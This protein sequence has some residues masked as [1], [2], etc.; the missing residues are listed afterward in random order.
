MKH[1]IAAFALLIALAAP[2]LAE[3]PVADTADTETA[4]AFAEAVFPRINS[5]SP[6]HDPSSL[7]RYIRFF[8][9]T[10]SFD[11]YKAGIEQSGVA[12]IAFRQ[13]GIVVTEIIS[14]TIGRETGEGAWSAEFVART[15]TFSGDTE[16]VDCRSVKVALAELPSAPGMNAVGITSI[17]TSKT[18][19]TCPKE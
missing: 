18:K 13:G 1:P 16:E 2:A 7:D 19:I 10:A 8:A 4:S 14:K 5:F 9:T 11:E 15:K 12:D 3:G 6:G 17:E